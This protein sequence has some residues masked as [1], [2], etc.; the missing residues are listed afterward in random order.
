MGDGNIPQQP[1]RP[2]ATPEP[3]AYPGF[4]AAPPPQEAAGYPVAGYQPTFPPACNEQPPAPQQALNEHMLNLLQSMAQIQVQNQVLH[5]QAQ[6]TAFNAAPAQVHTPGTGQTRYVRVDDFVTC[7]P[8]VDFEDYSRRAK[9]FQYVW[10]S[11][12]AAE[13]D[14]AKSI[15]DGL[16]TDIRRDIESS[17]SPE[18]LTIRTVLD[19]VTEHFGTEY[20]TKQFSL[21]ED[22]DKFQRKSN[23]LSSYVTEFEV[24]IQKLK[25]VGYE[26]S[27]K[28]ILLIS[29]AQ[30]TAS[31]KNSMLQV[32]HQK[33]LYTGNDATYSEIRKLLLLQGQS[34]DNFVRVRSLEVDENVETYCGRPYDKGGRRRSAPYGKDNFRR[35]NDAGKGVCIQWT[36]GHC[37]FGPSCKFTHSGA[38][39][40]RDRSASNSRG[41]QASPSPRKDFAGKRAGSPRYRQEWGS[42]SR[43]PQGYPQGS[44]RQ[45]S[46]RKGRQESPRKG[47]PRGG[48]K[49]S[50]RKGSPRG[51]KKGFQGRQG[52]PRA[53]PNSYSE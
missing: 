29:K 10:E 38:N 49:G 53:A 2:P 19:F 24:W 45:G 41:R 50:P 8:R 40:G 28:H 27:H 52:S 47:S 42:R 37:R 51:G 16:P 36:N 48:K 1:I 46:P 15:K 35:G 30:L 31:A 3:P 32:L 43:S 34:S 21:I 20:E 4:F 17:T 22:F 5:A 14:I 11:R 33:K 12:R 25:A 39:G 7:D 6:T 44:P 18:L 23:S 13:Y 26:P 9:E